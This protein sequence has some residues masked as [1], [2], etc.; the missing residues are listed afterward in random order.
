MTP[1][2]RVREAVPYP[3][4]ALSARARS[5]ARQGL[6]VVNLSIGDPDTPPPQRAIDAVRRYAGHAG[7]HR[8]PD[9]SGDQRFRTAVAAYYSRRFG[10]A[11]D[12]D[13]EI[14]GLI[15]SKEGIAHLLW[16]FVESGT[17]A[18]LPDPGYPVY[19]A[20][21]RFAGG[22]VMRVPLMA[23]R[24]FL[25]D[26][27]TLSPA[28]TAQVRVLMLNYP[29]APTGAVADGRFWEQAVAFGQTHGLLV[30]NDGAYLD[31]RLDPD[32]ERPK[33]LLSVPEGRNVSLEFFS[34]SKTYHMTGWR[35]AAA[36]GS[37]QAIAALR[38]IQENTNSGQWTAL[39]W[40]AADLLE[41]PGLD[42]YIELE[43][44]RLRRRRDSLGAAL[45]RAGL[46]VQMPQAA[47]Y[48]W[49]PIPDGFGTEDVRFAE[50]L[51]T[52]T[53]ILSTPGSAFGE[54]GK[55][56]IRLS[57]TASD[58]EIA[59]AITTLDERRVPQAPAASQG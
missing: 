14:V 27:S 33:S 11:L 53:G 4:S 12:P 40:A 54:G 29:N 7:L 17:T 36:V 5:L 13:R 15:G 45:A 30:V 21:T 22:T 16:A 55:G 3:F 1:A 25:P 34:L 50:D 39:Q 10:V 52:H 58:E 47:L 26:L 9:P 37:A 49:L 19:A 18:L 2:R 42:T 28:V 46:K 8:Y 20:Q 38:A 41:D 24:G 59:Q 32:G 44:A 51:L 43:N 6:P 23:E 48:F 57:L 35:L 56:Y 31:V